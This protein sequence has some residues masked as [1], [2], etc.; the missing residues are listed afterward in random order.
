MFNPRYEGTYTKQAQIY[1][2]DSKPG[3]PYLIVTLNGVAAKPSI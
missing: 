1:L 3:Q 2:E